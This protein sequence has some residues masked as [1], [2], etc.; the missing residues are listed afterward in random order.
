MTMGYDVYIVLGSLTYSSPLPSMAAAHI[1]ALARF[2]CTQNIVVI[3][4]VG[5]KTVPHQ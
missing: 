4:V 1:D 3:V 5:I 2:I